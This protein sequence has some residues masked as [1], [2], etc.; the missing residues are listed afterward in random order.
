[1]DTSDTIFDGYL[2]TPWDKTAIQREQ[3]AMILAMEE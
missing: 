3:D 1:M 2:M